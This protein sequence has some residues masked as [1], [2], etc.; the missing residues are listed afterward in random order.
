MKRVESETRAGRPDPGE[1][2][3]LARPARETS[4]VMYALLGTL[5]VLAWLILCLALRKLL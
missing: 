5:I 3:P 4:G 2:V 1:P